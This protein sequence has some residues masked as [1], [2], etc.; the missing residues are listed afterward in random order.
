MDL[1]GDVI[2]SFHKNP[3]LFLKKKS[4]LNIYQVFY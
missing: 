4:E 1:D 2:N 3:S